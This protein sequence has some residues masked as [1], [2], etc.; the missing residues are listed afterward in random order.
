MKTAT[1]ID[2]GD[3]WV[4]VYIDGK[5]VTQGHR[6]DPR[7]LLKQLGYFVESPEPDYEWMDDV[8]YL[9]EDLKD[10]VLEEN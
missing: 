10:V 2:N 1:I 9:P 3:D 7:E 4:G 8:S 6:I 5:L